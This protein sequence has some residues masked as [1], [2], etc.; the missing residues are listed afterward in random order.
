MEV[1]AR[2][3]RYACFERAASALGATRVA[4]GHTQDDQAETVLLR[5]VRGAGS[6]GLSAIRPR[7]GMYVRPLIDCRRADLREYLRARGESFREDWSNLDL[8]VPR[9][10]L[11][12]AVLPVVLEH[13]PAAVAALA[14]FAEVSADDERF[15]SETAREVSS[16]VALPP[17]G[18]VQ[19]VDVRGL[20]QL[21]AALARRII[22]QAIEAQGA[23]PTFRDIEA[24]RAL[25]RADKPQG[26][27]DL[28]GLVVERDGS[29]LRFGRLPRP[30]CPPARSNTRSRFPAKW[31]SLKLESPFG[32][33]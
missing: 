9:N 27:L 1:A 14:R 8:G 29:A 17:V 10:R 3:E 11:R 15:L 32:R 21:P 22:R 31:S 4:T 2:A 7:R 33:H 26:H 24:V 23:A 25:T 13:W 6:R 20:S 16:A 12:H 18:G 28:P 19:Q 30:G 5:L